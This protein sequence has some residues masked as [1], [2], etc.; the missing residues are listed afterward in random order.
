MNIVTRELVADT[1][2]AALPELSFDLP[3]DIV[4]AMR[5]AWQDE[6]G[7]RSKEALGIVLENA[8]IA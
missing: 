7:T 6:S 3:N 8:R 4:Q 5:A 2:R 1:L